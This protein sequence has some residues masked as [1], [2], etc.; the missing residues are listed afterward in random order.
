MLQERSSNAPSCANRYMLHDVLRG[1][2]KWDGY[3]LSDAGATA[4]VGK[5][6]VGKP[7]DLWVSAATV[8]RTTLS[9]DGRRLLRAAREQQELRAW[10]RLVAGGRRGQSAQ[11][12]PGPRADM[13]RC[14]DT[15]T[16]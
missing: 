12:W 1:E 4:F 11:R 5:T 6:Q 14:A 3:I 13:L 10:L 8:C 9:S 2:W 7:G 16:Y 15:P